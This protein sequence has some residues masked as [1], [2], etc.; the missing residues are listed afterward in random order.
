M[1]KQSKLIKAALS[2][3]ESLGVNAT[4]VMRNYRG[5]RR[6]LKINPMCYCGH[7]WLQHAVNGDADD[8]RCRATNCGCEQYEEEVLG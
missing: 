2:L 4:Y 8:M 3:G 5:N 7:R 6:A 1:S